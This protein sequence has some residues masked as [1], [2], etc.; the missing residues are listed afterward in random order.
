MAVERGR[1]RHE[2]Q[3]AR[4]PQLPISP[5][6]HLPMSHKCGANQPAPFAQSAETIKR[7]LTDIQS[8]QQIKILLRIVAF[9]IIEQTPSPAYHP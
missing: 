4:I 5:W 9:H 8:A 3:P 6:S 1:A 7:S 2:F